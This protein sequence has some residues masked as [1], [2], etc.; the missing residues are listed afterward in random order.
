M[1]RTYSAYNDDETGLRDD[2][3]SRYVPPLTPGD[4]P[5]HGDFTGIPDASPS[6]IYASGI[7]TDEGEHPDVQGGGVK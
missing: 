1:S 6:A 7:S 3:N 5:Y 4:S 2:Q